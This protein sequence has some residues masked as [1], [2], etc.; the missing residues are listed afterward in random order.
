V[1]YL[2][3][4]GGSDEAQRVYLARG[5]SA[6]P[7]AERHLR[8]EEEAGITLAWVDLDEAVAA[9]LDGRIHNSGAVVGILAAAAARAHGWAS[10]REAGSHWSTHPAHRPMPREDLRATQP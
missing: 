9:V 8:S 7:E 3:S 2:S 10:V 6:V 5:L 4:P 1:D